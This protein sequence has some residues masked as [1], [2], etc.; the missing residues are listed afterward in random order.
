MDF[1]EPGATTC[2]RAFALFLSDVAGSQSGAPAAADPGLADFVSFLEQSLEHDHD[3]NPLPPEQN[4][5]SAC[6]SSC[7]DT[8]G[9]LVSMPTHLM[10]ISLSTRNINQKSSN[11]WKDCT[12]HRVQQFRNKVYLSGTGKPVGPQTARNHILKELRGKHVY[13]PQLDK[14]WF[15]EGA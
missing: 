13:D 6:C 8:T 9:S 15:I 14:L 4:A 1:G 12:H 2:T 7:V 10:P 5:G 3:P 11:T